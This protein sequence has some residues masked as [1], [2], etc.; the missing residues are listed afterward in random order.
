M[1][2]RDPV[3]RAALDIGD[4]RGVRLAVEMQRDLVR[5]G[6]DVRVL[7][8]HLVKAQ[9]E[10]GIALHHIQRG[11]LRRRMIAVEDSGQV[12]MR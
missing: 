2:A 4:H 12:D 7:Q 10:I 3:R 5:C 8:R 11:C 6:I 9:G 1:C